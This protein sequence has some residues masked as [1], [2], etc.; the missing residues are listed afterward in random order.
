MPFHDDILRFI[1]KTPISSMIFDKVYGPNLVSEGANLF[2]I[3]TWFFPI[4][5][6]HESGINRINRADRVQNAGDHA[7]GASISTLTLSLLD[8][9]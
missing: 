5:R 6:V 7:S 1:K 9:K 4:F 2:R 3:L 8:Q